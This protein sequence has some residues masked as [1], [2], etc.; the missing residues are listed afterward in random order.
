MPEGDS[1]HTSTSATA[2]PA[3]HTVSARNSGPSQQYATP[4]T[5]D[6]ASADTTALGYDAHWLCLRASDAGACHRR[7]RLFALA[8]QPS[9]RSRLAR[10]AR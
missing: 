9:A 5:P 1:R 6:M 2:T 3:T 4:G 10:A 7:D 8:W